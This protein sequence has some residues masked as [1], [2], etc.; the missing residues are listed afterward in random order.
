MLTSRPDPF[1]TSY[2]IFFENAI[3]RA[4]ANSGTLG[5]LTAKL[6]EF[7]AVTTV[8]RTTGEGNRNSEEHWV[9]N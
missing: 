7:T 8:P 6:E 9:V 5:H 3:E 1:L 2:S 4:E